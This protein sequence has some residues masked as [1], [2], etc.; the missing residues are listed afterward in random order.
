MSLLAHPLERLGVGFQND[1]ALDLNIFR[2]SF[3][4]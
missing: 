3:S 4:L 2:H 1:L